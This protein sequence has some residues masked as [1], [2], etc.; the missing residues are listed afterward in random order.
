MKERNKPLLIAAGVVLLAAIIVAVVML[1]VGEKPPVQNPPAAAGTTAS[2]SAAPE[3]TI[4]RMTFLEDPTDETAPTFEVVELEIPTVEAQEASLKLEA[5]DADFT[6]LLAPESM[7]RGYSGTGYLAGFACNPGDHVLGLMEIPASQHYDIT[8]SV[9]S[10]SPV[11]NALLLN[12]EEV[13]E[14]TLEGTGEFIR[15]TFSGI[16]LEAGEAELSIREIDGHFALDYFELTDFDEMY[17]MEYDDDYKLSDPKASPGA[18]LLMEFLSDHYGKKVITG[19]YASSSLNTET[20]LI[21]SVT[22][23]YPAIRFSAMQ[24]LTEN[25]TV[26]RYD[27]IDACIDWAHHGGIV[28]LM[29]YWDAPTGVSSVYAKETD[30]SL[31]TAMTKEDIALL[32]QEEIDKMYEAGGMTDA[33][34]AV[35]RDIDAVSETL[36]PLAEQD[37]PVLWRPLHEAGGGW[38]WWGSGGAE[39]YR[40]LWQLMYTRMTEYHGLHNLIWVWNGQNPYFM[41]EGTTFDI[42]SMDIYLGADKD[43]SSRYEQYVAMSRMTAGEKLLALSECSSVPDMNDMFRDNCIWS[44]FGL[45]YG[46]Y[47]MDENG[48]Y[49]DTFTSEEDMVAFYNSEA[50]VTRSDV[51]AFYESRMQDPE[52]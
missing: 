29:W 43:Y 26:P 31:K 4:P 1:F 41:V 33:C 30:F 47:L 2:D 46:N 38:F 45:W 14:F 39:A 50:A 52:E 12:G 49:S 22:G 10:D 5:E 8:I 37:I 13:G 34:Y 23:K 51:R 6:G 18:K 21:Y 24:G 35:L 25:T 44:F 32:S 48:A 7:R 16:Y 36:R 27:G 9:C 40:W 42:A 20:D 19:Q 3:E 28:G 11:T 15:V 17:A